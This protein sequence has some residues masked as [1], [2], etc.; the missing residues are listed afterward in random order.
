MQSISNI[1]KQA[2]LTKW[3][4]TDDFDLFFSNTKINVND[5]LNEVN[6]NIFDLCTISLSMPSMSAPEID[7]VLGGERRIG[8]RMHEAFRFNIR[9]RD[10]YG[11]KLREYFSLIWIAQQYEYFDDIK[12]TV[13]ITQ[14]DYIIFESNDAIITGVSG[15]SY[16]NNNTAIGEFEIN[17]VAKKF[18]SDLIVSYGASNF[19]DYFDKTLKIENDLNT[20]STD[21]GYG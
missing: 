4:L 3:N 15:I 19:I 13:K 1:I 17:I 20:D 21:Y 8:V 11:G 16:D 9:L 12:N 6:N 7:D 10:L 18:S 2:S 14:G 5:V